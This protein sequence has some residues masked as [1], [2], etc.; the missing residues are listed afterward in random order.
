MTFLFF[1]STRFFFS[2]GKKVEKKKN[3][4]EKKGVHFLFA[5][6]SFCSQYCIQ[7]NFFVKVFSFF[8]GFVLLHVVVMRVTTCVREKGKDKKELTEKKKKK[9]MPF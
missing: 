2:K 7:E 6:S 8:L 4:R 5:R 3:E 1:L 9:Q